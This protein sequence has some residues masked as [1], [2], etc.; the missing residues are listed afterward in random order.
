M[1]K[2]ATKH[3]RMTLREI[4]GQIE[5]DKR[6]AQSALSSLTRSIAA[7]VIAYRKDTAM[8]KIEQLSTRLA[9]K[10]LGIPVPDEKITWW[11]NRHRDRGIGRPLIMYGAKI[12]LRDDNEDKDTDKEIEI[13]DYEI[14]NIENVN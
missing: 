9:A 13:E 14:E 8:A 5:S 1:P 10:A 6:Y 7:A 12:K 11:S 2:I 4:R 3:K